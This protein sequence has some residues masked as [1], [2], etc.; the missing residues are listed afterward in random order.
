MNLTRKRIRRIDKEILANIINAPHLQGTVSEAD[1]AEMAIPS[2]LHNNPF[3]RAIFWHRYD[4][5]YWLSGL[6]PDLKVCEFGCGI[7][8]FLPTLA[9]EVKEVYAVD[10]YPQYA[11]ELAK[12]LNLD[13]NFSKDMT[14]IPDGSLDVIISVEVMEHLDDPSVFTQLFAQKLKPNG[15]LIMSG[16][17]ESWFYKQTR[18]L[19]GYNKYHDYHQNN[20]HQLK[21]IIVENGFSLQKTI[22]YPSYLMPLFLICTF[23]VNKR[24]INQQ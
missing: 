19:I 24:T 21:Q 9:S 16:P 18:S 2:Y 3:I 5:V 20:V 22:R 17:T 12:E 15:R 13:V 23:H 14:D 6:H 1:Q 11:H 8:V 10:L 4:W 7:G